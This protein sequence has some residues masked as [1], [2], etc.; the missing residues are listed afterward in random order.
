LLRGQVGNVVAIVESRKAIS[1]KAVSLEDDGQTEMPSQFRP[2]DSLALIEMP[3]GG[4][5]EDW[6]SRVVRVLAM[7][8]H[9]SSKVF[10]L[11]PSRLDSR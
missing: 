7:I 1:T 5:G 11:F 9:S 6:P 3:P 10:F 8:Y 4:R 2:T